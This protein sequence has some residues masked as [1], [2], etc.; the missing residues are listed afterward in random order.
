M[1]NLK[2]KKLII[3]IIIFLVAIFFRF[4]NFTDNDIT[5]DDALYSF[6]ALGWFDYL[7]GGQ[8]TPV[9][10]FDE[11]PWWGKLSFHDGPP[12]V[13]AIQNV[14]FK[15][16]GPNVLGARLPFALAGL[17]VFVLIYFIVKIFR[18][19]KAA[20]LAGFFAAISTL[21]VWGSR[22]GFLE[23]MAV[24]FITLSILFFLR[25]LKTNKELDLLFWGVAVG[26]A[27]LSKYTAIFL[28]PAIFLFLLI[29]RRKIFIRKEFWIALILLV[30]VL[31][32]VIIYN[33]NVFQ[34]RGHFDAA[35]SSMVGMHPEDFSAI[36]SRGVGFNWG[37][38]AEL[39]RTLYKTASLPIFLLFILSL[40]YLV[41][42]IFRRKSNLYENFLAINI[43]MAFFMF[44]F[45]GIGPK[46][47]LIVV[48]FLI[49]IAILFVFD[50]LR[51]LKRRE[52][53][54]IY[55]V[56]VIILVIVFGAELLYSINTN[57]V[58]K[59]VGRSELFYSST[60]FYDYGFNR[61]DDYLQKEIFVSLPTIK[62]VNKIDDLAINLEVFQG[63]DV[64]FFDETISWFA[65]SWYLQKYP[66]FYK[67][68]VISFYNYLQISPP[69]QDP[70]DLL[71]QL[72]VNG[73]YYIFAV[74]DSVLDPVKKD[75][76]IM[77][78]NMKLL[79]QQLEN[80]NIDFKEIKNNQGV[81]AF[82]IFYVKF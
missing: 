2:N 16:F 38:F 64:V 81:V 27:L 33:I 32:P 43:L 20:Q 13:F 70:F 55:K 50:I 21:A 37:V 54:V 47:L 19:K 36:S 39:I 68:P 57:L 72:G 48:P 15:S 46:F 67:L 28:L 14:F 45:S 65:Y 10:W 78:D 31:L 7:G 30:V 41:V 1:I 74:D 12:A 4:Y 8:T 49:I 53:L 26:L 11:I 6:R 58:K 59:P 77:R 63:K 51:F 40:I 29:Y 9:Q 62:S 5:S 52:F 44:L 73:F 25:Y 24:F 3:L 66:F 80:N 71:R 82:K 75:I 76:S 61:L 17:G 34:T 60:R 79:A 35:L 56:V 69:D 23:G 18:D 42:K 22:V